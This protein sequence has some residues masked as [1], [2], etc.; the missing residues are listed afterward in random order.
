MTLVFAA[1]VAIVG[2]FGLRFAVNLHNTVRFRRDEALL[3]AAVRRAHISQSAKK[4]A[5]KS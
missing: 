5:K 3:N 2:F 4:V 1:L